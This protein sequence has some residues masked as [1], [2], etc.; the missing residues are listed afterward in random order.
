[1]LGRLPLLMLALVLLGAVA[2]SLQMPAPPLS[3]DGDNRE[4]QG[5][6]QSAL[7]AQSALGSSS[8]EVNVTDSQIELAGSVPTAR[9]KQ[10][11]RRIAQSYGNNRTV[12]D[13]KIVVRNAAAG[14]EAA[15]H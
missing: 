1:M 11:A 6:I 15:Q 10:T 7:T 13:R 14:T 2:V 8:F 12:E 3:P 4:I 9:E 5:Q